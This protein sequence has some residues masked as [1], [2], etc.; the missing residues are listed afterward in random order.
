MPQQTPNPVLDSSSTTSV[1]PLEA[2]PAVVVASLLL[3][4]I[5]LTLLDLNNT[6]KSIVSSRKLSALE[7]IA[8]QMEVG[9]L[10]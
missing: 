10:D 2:S 6:G 7:I 4:P 5:T 9:E 8:L 1:N 3:P